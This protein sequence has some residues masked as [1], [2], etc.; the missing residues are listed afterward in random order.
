M[1]KDDYILDSY[2]WIE[3][4]KGE[5]QGEKIKA[6][7]DEPKNQIY[8]NAV[9]IAE[10][11]SITLREKRDTAKAM[12]S[13][14]SNSKIIRVDGEFAKEAGELHAE[15]KSNNRN[16]S[17]GDA[18]ALLT[19]RKLDAKI[20]TG[21]PDFRGIKNVIMINDRLESIEKPKRPLRD[22]LGALGESEEEAEEM[23]KKIKES[24]ERSSKSE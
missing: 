16:F 23:K 4:F 6:L 14:I 22:F 21:D 10:I 20:V 2:A 11:M 18:F 5:T 12:E 17:Y 1:T 19:A 9:N 7:V 13:I 8:T 24:R 3:F 15:M